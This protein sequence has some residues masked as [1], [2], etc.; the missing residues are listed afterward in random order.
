L[1]DFVTSYPSSRRSAAGD[2]HGAVG[3]QRGVVEARGFAIEAT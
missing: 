2:E 1:T 3:Q